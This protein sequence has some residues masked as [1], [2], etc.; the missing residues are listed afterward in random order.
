[1]IFVMRLCCFRLL[2]KSSAWWPVQIASAEDV[3]VDVKDRLPS[4]RSVVEDHAEIVKTFLFGGF[5]TDAQHFANQPLVF[6]SDSG[7]PAD[8][9]FRN[10]EKMYRRT[11]IDV[12]EGKQLVILK[13]LG[14]RNFSPDDLAENTVVS[15]EAVLQIKVKD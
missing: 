15:H 10:H 8:V 7:R 3:H 14:G 13:E 1:M 2:E 4:L 11:G 5:A 6:G 9:L 12:A